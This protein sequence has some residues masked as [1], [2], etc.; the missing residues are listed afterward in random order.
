MRAM[1]INETRDAN[2]GWS[3]K[4]KICGKKVNVSFWGWLF[5]SSTYSDLSNFHATR[6]RSG[7]SH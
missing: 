2:G 3:V 6:G 7:K 4:C 5:R 1:T